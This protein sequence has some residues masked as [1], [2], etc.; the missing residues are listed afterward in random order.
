MNRYGNDVPYI[1]YYRTLQRLVLKLFVSSYS[2]IKL[3]EVNVFI[4]FFSRWFG[5]CW[6]IHNLLKYEFDIE[7]DVSLVSLLF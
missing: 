6:H 4:I 3:E 5:K 7:F 1:L 2:E